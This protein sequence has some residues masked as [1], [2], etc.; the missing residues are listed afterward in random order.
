MIALPL[1]FASVAS[2]DTFNLTSDDCSA[3]GGSACGPPG[4]VFGSVD[5]VQILTGANA[6]IQLTVTL[7]P[8]AAQGLISTGAAGGSGYTFDFNLAGNPTITESGFTL[9]L[10]FGPGQTTGGLGNSIHAD[11]TGDFEYS[12]A[13]TS[14]GSGAD[15][16]NANPLV[17]DV[18][19]PDITVASFIQSTG[20]NGGQF[21]AAD[22]LSTNGATGLVDASVN[23]STTPL[24]SS[25][26]LFGSVLLGGLGISGWKR[27]R[28]GRSPVSGFS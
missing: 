4:T 7:N 6:E 23:N 21:F 14:C 27:R 13:C 9:G 20:A 2:A 8:S 24:P 10:G 12:V 15:H 5:V 22:I 25:V 18:S 17:F 16:P 11:G 28:G 3:S 26:F 1:G 19:A